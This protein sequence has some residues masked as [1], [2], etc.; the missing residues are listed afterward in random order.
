MGSWTMTVVSPEKISATDRSHQQVVAMFMG[1]ICDGCPAC[2]VAGSVSHA[3]AIAPRATPQPGHGV[4][5]MLS[6]AGVGVNPQ[7]QA[8]SHKYM[9]KGSKDFMFGYK[10]MWTLAPERGG[11]HN[12][13]GVG[14]RSAVTALD[15]L[16][17]L[18]SR[19]DY[20]IL[21]S[22]R[23]HITG[24]SRGGHGALVFGVNRPDR[25][26]KRASFSCPFSGCVSFLFSGAVLPNG[27][28][29]RPSFCTVPSQFHHSLVGTNES[30][31]A[32]RILCLSWT[33]S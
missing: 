28:S 19:T 29:L 1:L 23:V 31:M 15:A 12:W 7:K 2:C 18:S 16:T 24:H 4:G 9:P 22:N 5:V 26:V 11:A 33:Y 21:D 13:E 32:M 6:F 14:S 8:E 27:C 10:H 20:P 3:A 25:F 17:H 30:T